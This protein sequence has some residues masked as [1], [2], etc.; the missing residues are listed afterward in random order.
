MFDVFHHTSNLSKFDLL[1]D[2]FVVSRS[3]CSNVCLAECAWRRTR[4]FQT[5]QIAELEPS[6]TIALSSPR[7]VGIAQRRM[8]VRVPASYCSYN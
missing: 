3:K 5:A 7:L 8:K 1:T 6:S 4:E 2:A